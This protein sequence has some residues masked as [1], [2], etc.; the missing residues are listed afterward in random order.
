MEDEDTVFDLIASLY[1]V[2][3]EEV[4][5]PCADILTV[6][7]HAW[8]QQSPVGF[9]LLEDVPASFSALRER[10]ARLF[11]NGV[12]E[13]DEHGGYVA[14]HSH[15]AHGGPGPGPGH[16][17]DHAPRSATVPPVFRGLAYQPAAEQ[18]TIW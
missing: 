7:C 9:P 16:R 15:H 11:A 5:G 13:R 2:V 17:H 18:A 4:T 8:L 12:Y 10:A 3:H 6:I 14:A 1:A